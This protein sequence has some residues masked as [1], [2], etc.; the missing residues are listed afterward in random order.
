MDV[1]GSVLLSDDFAIPNTAWAFFDTVEGAA[2]V[3][4]EELYLEDRGK[5]VGIYTGLVNHTWE[6]TIIQVRLRQIEGTQN[7]WMGIICRQQDE[8]NY[9]LFAISADGYYL[10][11]KVQDGVPTKLAGPLAN[12]KINPGR[13]TNLLEARCD[14]PIL[15]LG[16][17]GERLVSRTDASFESGSVALFADAVEGGRATTV[18]F[19]TFIISE[20]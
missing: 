10:L 2:Y 14:G 8:N 7:N 11:L 19:D 3:Q 1:S 4:Q 5:G 20:P 13:A 9:Y 12:A 15:T 6:N 16:V 17:N 18:A